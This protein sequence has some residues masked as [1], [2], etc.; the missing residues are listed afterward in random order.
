MSAVDVGHRIRI[1]RT[2]LKMKQKELADAVGVSHVYI[3]YMERGARAINAE[4][5]DHIATALQCQPAD[6]LNKKRRLV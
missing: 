2:A 1:R 5:L 4:M 3:S 6:L